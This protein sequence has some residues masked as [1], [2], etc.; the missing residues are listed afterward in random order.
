M[1]AHIAEWQWTLLPPAVSSPGQ[2]ECHGA[3]DDTIRW[4]WSDGNNIGAQEA[5]MSWLVKA[6]DVAFQDD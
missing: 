4:V 6:K 5:V 3:P 1:P 2:W